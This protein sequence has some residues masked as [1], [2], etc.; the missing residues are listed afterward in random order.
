MELFNSLTLRVNDWA[1]SRTNSTFNITGSS[2]ED[3]PLFLNA[4]L[5]NPNSSLD[6]ASHLIVLP[7]VS[8]AENLYQTLKGPTFEDR[9]IYFPSLEVNPYSTILPS[10]SDLYR[11]FHALYRLSVEHTKH[12]IVITSFEGMLMILPPPSI[13]S[14]NIFTLKIS[15]IIAPYDLAKN[16]VAMGYV[17]NS[18][19]E[20]AGTFSKRGE[21]FDIYPINGRPIRL[22]YFDEMIEEMFYISIADQRTDKSK[23]IEQ[24]DIC[25]APPAILKD[26]YITNF[27]NNIPM[28]SPAFKER[29]K[30]RT[31]VFSQLSSNQLFKEYP[32]FIPLFF[33]ESFLLSDYIN[34]SNNSIVTILN[35][36]ETIQN[37]SEYIDELKENFELKN[38]DISSDNLLP[39]PESIFFTSPDKLLNKTAGKKLLVDEVNLHSHLEID[40]ENSVELKIEPA[41]IFFNKLVP[42]K[43]DN[44]SFIKQILEKLKEFFKSSGDIYVCSI[45]KFFRDELQYLLDENSFPQSLLQ[46]I[47]YINNNIEKGFYYPAEKSLFLSEGDLFTSKKIK[48][49][50]HTPKNVDLFAEQMASLK[51]GD[52]VVH[53]EHGIGEYCGLETL[54]VGGTTNDYLTIKYLNE[55]KVYV[56]VYKINLIQ[57]YADEAAKVSVANLRLNKFKQIKERAK[58]SAKKLAFDLLRLQAEREASSAYAFSTPD[59]HFNEFELEFP[60]RETDDQIQAIHNVLKDMQKNSPMDHLVCGDVGFGKTE[61]AMRAAYLAVLDKKQ[62]AVLV[63]TTILALQHYNSFCDR[64]KKFPV[65]VEFLSRFKSAK[66]SLAIKDDLKEGKIDILIGTHKLLSDQVSFHDLGLVIVDEEQRFGVGHKEKLKLMKKSVDF[67]TLTATPIP[68]TMQM[69]FLGLRDLSL[70]QTPPPKRQS[71]K[72]YITKY[73]DSV[74]KTAIEKELARG[75]QI[76]FVHNKVMSIEKKAIELQ[77]LVPTAKILIAHGQLPEKELEKRMVDFYAGYFNILLSTTIIE[78]GLDIP[79]ANTLIIDRADTFGLSQLHQLRGRIGRSTKKAYAYFTVPSNRN[80]TEIAEKRLKALQTYADMGSGFS[81]ASSDLE[82]RGAGDILGAEQSGH[83]NEIGLELYMDLLKESIREIKGER[84]S[85]NRN[86]EI[87]TPF[88]AFIPNDFIP[89]ASER[90]KYYKKISNASSVEVIEAIRGEM[91]D[92]FGHFPQEVNN[93]F[94]IILTRTNLIEVG[95]RSAKVTY[96]KIMISFDKMILDS[97]EK[98][99]NGIIEAFI[100]KPKKYIFSPDYMVT[101]THKE[102]LT[103]EALIALSKEISKEITN[104]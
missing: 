39:R 51:I 66:E 92:I 3:W 80:L 64:F 9:L 31:E 100:N 12:H 42:I 22:H 101:Y 44:F 16:L 38:D 81:I 30:R 21:I 57:K 2:I 48:T 62:V 74:I 86:I 85:N 58:G 24:V 49:S 103:P 61:V 36:Q 65:K 8:Q 71:I 6:N 10:E 54:D 75:G 40:L 47:H 93:L 96:E 68:R 35:S 26:E 94:S 7:S 55:D 84:Q 11:R 78:S 15:D 102:K 82:I 17:S 79:N 34:I 37:C 25:I 20:E 77:E 53:S 56:P 4:L 1:K 60:F 13:F 70:I 33:K 72:T 67:L 76:F 14:K 98:L 73:D 23:I 41:T 5:K 18:T 99:K 83:L 87:Q 59:H 89:N 43:T 69:A 45:N 29:H 90:L 28:P 63:P 50:K 46:R 91:H 27:K 95:V 19:A 88:P 32:A 104:Q 52:Y 97:D